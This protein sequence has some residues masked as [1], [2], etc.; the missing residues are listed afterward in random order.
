VTF[1][2]EPRQPLHRG[3][4]PPCNPPET[5]DDDDAEPD[6]DGAVWESECDVYETDIDDDDGPN[7][8]EQLGSRS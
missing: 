6:D 2:Y 1:P 4:E 8:P 5:V 7:L 3:L